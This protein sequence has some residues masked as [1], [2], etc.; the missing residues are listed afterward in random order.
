MK[1]LRDIVKAAGV[2]QRELA[3]DLGSSIP[4]VSRVLRREIRPP[5]DRWLQI[6]HAVNARAGVEVL[7]YEDIAA[8]PQNE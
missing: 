5:A 4:Y 2:S 7:R 6:V 1:N 3:A 8:A